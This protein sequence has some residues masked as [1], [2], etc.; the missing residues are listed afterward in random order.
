MSYNQNM[1]QIVKTDVYAEWFVNLRDRK[2]KNIILA[3]LRRVEL[4]NFG[5]SE[6]VGEG[7]TEIK[8]NFG[9]GYRIYTMRHGIE[10]VILLAGGDKSSQNRD[11]ANALNMAREMKESNSG[12]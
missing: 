7:V 5:N 12:Y 8:I 6:P 9:P 2:A 4:G 10:V 11:I 1:L 3:R